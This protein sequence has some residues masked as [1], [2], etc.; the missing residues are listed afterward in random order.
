MYK[1]YSSL[2]FIQPLGSIIIKNFFNFDVLSSVCSLVEMQSS[3]LIL[4]NDLSVS[5][6]SFRVFTDFGST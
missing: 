2:S 1:A 6:F 4:G 5:D 3:N